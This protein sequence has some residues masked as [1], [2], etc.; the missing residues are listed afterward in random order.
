MQPTE[1]PYEKCARLKLNLLRN[2]LRT[3]NLFTSNITATLKESQMFASN[4][5]WCA[6]RL[7]A[8]RFQLIFLQRAIVTIC[9]LVHHPL[10]KT[11]LISNI[12][13]KNTF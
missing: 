11:N 1:V 9:A 4:F 3:N 13:L 2:A 10:M 5:L 8:D 12:F 6:P 7:D